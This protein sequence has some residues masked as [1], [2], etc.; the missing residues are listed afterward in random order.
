MRHLLATLASVAAMALA[1]AACGGDDGDGGGGTGSSVSNA[2]NTAAKDPAND[3]STNA[4]SAF[5][6]LQDAGLPAVTV[7]GSGP[8]VTKVN[9][10]VFSDGALVKGLV[11]TANIRGVA[12]AKL[13]PGTSGQPDRWESYI[14]RME[15]TTG[16][17]AVGPN[18]TPVRA[19]ALQ[20]NND[21]NAASQL[22]ENADG[23]YTY[24]FRA[25]IKDPNWKATISGT[26]YSTGVAFEPGRTHRIAIQLSY[27]NAAGETVITNP[28]WDFTL[29]S[30]GKAVAV[31]DPSKTKKMAD[32]ANCNGCHD[33]LVLHGGV[34]N[35]YGRTDNNY[36]VMCH[37]PSTTDANSGNVLTMSTMTH[38]IHAGRLLHSL[39]GQGGEDY[40]IWG[41][42]ASKHEYSEVGFPQDL[43]NCAVCHN[44]S[45]KAPQGDN[46]KTKASKE[47]CL[48]CHVSASGTDWYNTHAGMNGISNPLNI[49]DDQC[50]SCHAS[51]AF[52][53]GRVHFN[54]NEDNSAKYKVNITDA[55]YDSASRTVTVK[56]NLSDPTNGN[57]R[58]NL[59]TSDCTGSGASLTCGSST[60]FG[61]L[62]FYLAYPNTKGQPAG[63]TEFSS[64]NNG[65]SG[66]NQY[67]YKGTNDG[68]NNYTVTITLPADNAA[69]DQVASGTARI[70]GIGQIKEPKQVVTWATDPR[71]D[72]S[73]VTLINVVAQHTYKD[74][75]LDGTLNS[76]R[77]VVSNEKCNVCH[78]A[79]GT[80]S[81]SN[82][83][84][85]A[86]HSGAR[87]T[88][89]SCTLCHDSNRSSSTVMA[90]GSQ[91]QEGYS[92]K[93][94]IHGIHGNSRRV[95]PYTHGN[96][97][98]GKWGKDG[99]LLTA[100][101]VGPNDT[102]RNGVR[103]TVGSAVP[104]GA[105]F[106]EFTSTSGAS[107]CGTSPS[108]E[109]YAAEVAYPSL[110]LSCD[111]CHVNGSFKQDRSTLGDT[112]QP[113]TSGTSSLSWKVISPKAASCS[114]CHD[115]NA[116][117]VH[118]Q[119]FGGSSYGDKTRAQV[120]SSPAETCND[121]HAP[122]GF[123]GVDIVHGQ[124]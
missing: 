101:V 83:L 87:N 98:F 63:T 95:A 119:S 121:C 106:S 62:R 43:R 21:P 44:A 51:G 66:A 73:P 61:N 17:N 70:V 29:D 33:K 11:A 105:A 13:I 122:G 6:V 16:N 15:K 10:A 78:G 123:R 103:L 28:N 46:W 4:E 91:L 111:G 120:F 107:G 53:P 49:P 102:C 88:I 76:R 74:V 23:Y 37:N 90:D 116:A 25:D 124:K 18:G 104:I 113:R 30:N 34:A 48:T 40:T 24:T 22:V 110:G 47:A 82:T 72:V 100:G 109:N 35:G 93:R 3:T 60:R 115:S 5:K 45:A 52:S 64:Y 32:T 1:L 65:G 27:K 89:E 59:V 19:Q 97:V 68:S 79:L 67:L 58:Y 57:A 85:D 20:A 92:F 7:T 38:K 69:L 9:F 26:D 81:G 31:T 36:C 80:T 117:I 114:G 75:A 14:Y 56:Y 108:I 55:T 118:M 41:Y 8:S 12:I 77:S 39:K 42:Q 50:Q 71:P 54:Q 2:L 99:I 96:R 86:F 84:P 94:M 112:V